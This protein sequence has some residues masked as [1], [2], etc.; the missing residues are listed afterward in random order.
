MDR[1][2]KLQ[3]HSASGFTV[4]EILV[5]IG[6]ITILLALLLPAVQRS[7]QTARRTECLSRLRQ[8]GVAFHNAVEISGA[9]PTSNQPEGSYLRLLPHLDAA[10]L[11]DAV[12]RNDLSVPK[13]LVTLLCPDDELASLADGGIANFLINEGT[14]FGVPN[15]FT[16]YTKDLE[17][18]EIS[19]GL[20]NTAAMSERLWHPGNLNEL[21]QEI[22]DRNSMRYFWWTEVRYTKPGEETFAID[23]ALNHRTT[24]LPQ[25]RNF[26]VTDFELNSGYD[27]LLPPNKPASFNGPEDFDIIRGNVFLVPASSL[28]RGGVNLLF[29]D[30]SAKFISQEINLSIW[31][32]IGSRNGNE[33]VGEF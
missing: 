4:M 8:I 26:T 3:H 30:G 16:K 12:R 21:T 24:S 14:V 29:V 28:H 17:P 1:T 5:G 23:Q 18:S 22:A 2:R 32:A 9:F 20:S 11:A 13:R 27:H 25:V 33:S 6:C 31:H 7:R 15:G 19:D 10:P